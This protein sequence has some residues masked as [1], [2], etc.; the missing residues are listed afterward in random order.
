MAN[1]ILDFPIYFFFAIFPSFLWLN[2][3]L[4]ED[5]RPE[6]KN[7]VLEVFLLGMLISFPTLLTASA[8]AIIFEK[9]KISFLI[10]FL[11]ALTEEIFKFLVV[12]FYI[13]QKR[14]FDEPVDAMIYMIIS[15]LGFAAAE[16]FFILISPGFLPLKEIFQISFIRFISGT[17]LHALSCALFGFFIGLSFFRKK[18][19]GKLIF[20]GL[21]S[22]TFL[23]FFYNFSII[24]FEE[25]VGPIIS[26]FLLFISSIFVFFCF[27]KLKIK[28]EDFLKN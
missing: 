9:I 11:M 25:K 5:T 27:K 2:I 28:W 20:F 23:H 14:E 10:Q 4:K 13:F 24:S 21:L 7:L 26:L 16:N 1:L 12:R 19:R 17:F 18:E 6:P 22:A 3:Y 15:G 8:I